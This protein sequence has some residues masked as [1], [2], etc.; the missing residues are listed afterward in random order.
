[1]S[2]EFIIFEGKIPFNVVHFSHNFVWLFLLGW[3]I[4]LLISWL[5]SF[6]ETIKIT[7]QRV[8]LSRGVLSKD[9]EEV[10]FYRVK[11]TKFQ[12]TIFQRILG[13]GT[14]TLFSDDATAPTL[15]FTINQPEYY[16]EH[17]REC[18]NEERTRMGTFQLD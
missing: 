13:V 18:V 15:S 1:M 17:I 4:G 11:D 10:E 14:I 5:Q 9:V 3:N 16:R 12:Q 8:V 7:S 2:D 6:G